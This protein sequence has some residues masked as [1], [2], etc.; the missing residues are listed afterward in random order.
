MTFIVRLVDGKGRESCGFH[1]QSKEVMEDYV[2]AMMRNFN[3]YVQ[4]IMVYE[5]PTQPRC[6]LV[7]E[8]S[9]FV[10]A[11]GMKLYKEIYVGANRARQ[12]LPIGE[13]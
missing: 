13:H 6:I 1:T 4:R 9:L 11:E 12:S 5:A 10:A 2:L 3:I 8:H 7:G